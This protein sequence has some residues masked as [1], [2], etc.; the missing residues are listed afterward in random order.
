MTTELCFPAPGP[1]PG[2]RLLGEIIAWACPGLA[3]PHAALVGALGASGLDPG[4]AR[5]L[6]PRHAFARACKKLSD[7]RIIRPVAEDPTTITFQFTHESRAGDR[8]EYVL[9]TMLALDKRTGSV[10]CALPG[11]AA[12]A[13]EELDRCIAVR[14][15]SDVTRVIQKLFERQ[16]D[17]FPI[18]PSGGT[19]FV[20]HRH[21]AFTD[22]IQELLNRVGGRLLRFPVPAGTGEGDRSVTAAVAQGLAAVIAEHR[23]AVA[24][25]GT[26]AR[27]DT[28]ARAAERIRATR[29]KVQAY[30]EYLAGERVELERALEAAGDELRARVEHLTGEPVPTA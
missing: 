28:L 23:T 8:F 20:P 2:A 29:F 13:Q 11:L 12:L 22:R 3:V 15:G 10:S 5:E 25:F 18:R 6:A 17:L 14:T 4:V 26:D 30:A 19:Y 27:P 9:E 7:R 1:A 24:Q 16:A 21:A